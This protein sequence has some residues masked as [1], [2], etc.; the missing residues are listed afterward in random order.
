MQPKSFPDSGSNTYSTGTNTGEWY[1]I[2]CLEEAS[3]STNE[4]NG[5]DLSSQTL[6]AGIIIYGSFTSITVSS[7]VIRAYKR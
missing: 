6:P 4:T 3:I 5:D 1:A 7:G 2:Q